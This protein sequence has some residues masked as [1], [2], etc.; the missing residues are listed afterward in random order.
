MMS[1]AQDAKSKAMIRLLKRYRWEKHDPARREIARAVTVLAEQL[2][3]LPD[4]GD[5][6]AA[7]YRAKGILTPP[8]KDPPT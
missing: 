6:W 2:A 8:P 3:K 7:I 5:T 4:I 1:I